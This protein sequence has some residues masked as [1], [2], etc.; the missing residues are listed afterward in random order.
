MIDEK[1]TYLYAGQSYAPDRHGLLPDAAKQAIAAQSAAPAPTAVTATD[2]LAELVVDA[3]VAAAL[4]EAGFGD[5][6]SI[7]AASDTDLIAIVGVGDKTLEKIRLAVA[8]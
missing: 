1:A 2:P 4:R 5:V 7:R 6:A 3:R 8:G